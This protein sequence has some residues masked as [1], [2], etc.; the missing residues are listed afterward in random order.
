MREQSQG[1]DAF[2]QGLTRDEC[3]YPLGQRRMD[4]LS[5]WD[6]RARQENESK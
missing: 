4:W 6:Q 5:G 2:N 1:A 3:P